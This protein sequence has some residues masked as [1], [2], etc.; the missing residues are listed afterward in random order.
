LTE[1]AH[2]EDGLS[3]SN[4][5]VE[6]RSDHSRGVHMNKETTKLDA[7]KSALLIMLTQRNQKYGCLR[8]K[9]RAF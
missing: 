9:N 5:V 3:I 8:E 1:L 7:K 4:I 2:D 6:T